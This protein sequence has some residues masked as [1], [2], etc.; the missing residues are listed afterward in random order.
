MKKRR[1]LAPVY[2]VTL[3]VSLSLFGEEITD[4]GVQLRELATKH[5]FVVEIEGQLITTIHRKSLRGDVHEQLKRLLEEYDYVVTYGV[6]GSIRQVRILGPSGSQ[7]DMV[8]MR[9]EHRNPTHT[10]TSST[11]NTFSKGSEPT[12]HRIR[13]ELNNDR[14]VVNALLISS[15]GRGH[16][17]SLETE[18]NGTALVLP[19]SMTKMLGFRDAELADGST[20]TRIGE[21]DGRVSAL[22]FV[23]LGKVRIDNVKVIF[24]DDGVLGQDRFLGMRALRGF[25]SKIDEKKNEVILVQE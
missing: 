25:R 15:T 10:M 12:K 13:M 5:D 16:R 21:L 7:S 2:V 6:G 19:A 1:L 8:G 11:D 24:V 17:V 22:R 4:I 20:Q 9:M 3:C 18:M 23:Q 14:Y